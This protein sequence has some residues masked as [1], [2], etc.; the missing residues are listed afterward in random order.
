MQNMSVFLRIISLACLITTGKQ[1]LDAFPGLSWINDQLTIMQ[2]KKHC[3]SRSPEITPIYPHKDTPLMMYQLLK[4]IHNVFARYGITYWI[5]G[6]TLLGAVRNK[7][8]IPWDDDLDICI[9]HKDV[10]NV[11]ALEPFFNAIGYEMYYPLRGVIKIAPK[12]GTAGTYFGYSLKS[13]HI[14]IL[15]T[16][17]I[18]THIYFLP[19][20][21]AD[22][23]WLLNG[24]YGLVGYRDGSEI[25]IT[26]AE[27]YPLKEY[28]FGEITVMG[29]HNPM[30]YLHHLYGTDCM[31]IGYQW[32]N[33]TNGLQKIPTGKITLTEENR[34][35]AQPTGPLLDTP[36]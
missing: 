36:L 24:D 3:S 12:G 10:Q 21:F 25:Y 28:K 27:L 17:Q 6:G 7:G 11:L 9:D 30:P 2:C 31:D 22:V 33:H 8:I 19:T 34:G 35:P 13:P 5:D 32:H 14:D 23:Y 26:Q 16:E 18:D 4:D 20:I 1:S 29:P 15:F